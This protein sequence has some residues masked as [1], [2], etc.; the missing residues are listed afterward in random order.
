LYG[1]FGRA[2]VAFWQ[3]CEQVLKA[4]E[5]EK[6]GLNLKVKWTN[7][8]TSFKTWYFSTKHYLQLRVD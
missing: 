1:A 2:K 5:V 6:E 7:G 8:Q 3:H 4:F